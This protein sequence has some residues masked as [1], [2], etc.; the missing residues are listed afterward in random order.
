MD[1]RIDLEVVN[2][3]LTNIQTELNIVESQ[4]NKLVE[5]NLAEAW[6]SDQARSFQ[7]KMEEGASNIKAMHEKIKLI[8]DNVAQYSTNVSEANEA[9]T[10]NSGNNSN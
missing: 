5:L 2:R 1:L 9:V 4:Y 3:S 7:A 6:D 8:R 10:L